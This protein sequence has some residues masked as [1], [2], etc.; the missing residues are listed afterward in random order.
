V[1]TRAGKAKKRDYA[2]YR[3]LG[4]DAYRFGGER[5]CK[6]RQVR[7][8]LLDAAV[9]NEV[10]TLLENPQRLEEEYHRRMHPDTTAKNQDLGSVEGQ[11][12]KV[13]QGIGR[14]IDSYAEGVINKREF[15]PRVGRLRER[16]TKLEEQAQQLSDEASSQTE[17]QL[18][19]GRLEEFT[20]RVKEGLAESDWLGRREIIRALV[21]R[22]EVEEEGVQVVFRVNEL[23][24][25]Q[26]PE[27]G[28]LQHCR[29]SNQSAA[30]E[31]LS[32]PAGPQDGP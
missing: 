12:G 10:K 14:L 21:K 2:Y 6:N 28:S 26:C 15:E 31:H 11:L 9:W 32:Q 3:C 1:S 23:P 30:L 29:R 27:R 17:L 16:A 5:V 4:T 22:V 18:I 24:F 8:D 19:I 13:R 25:E 20:T 7:T